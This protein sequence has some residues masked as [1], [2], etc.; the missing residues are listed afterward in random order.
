[1][2]EKQLKKRIY[3]DYAATTPIDR[4][5][6]SAMR[7]YLKERF[8]NAGGLY[9]EGIEAR[10]TLEEARAHIAQG[11]KAK[12]HE[13]IFTSGGTEANNLAIRGVVRALRKSKKKTPHAIVSVIE[14][15]SV[16]E[17]FRE[18]HRE[19]V[20][21]TY[22]PVTSAGIVD[23][24][25]FL[26]AVT[27]ET[28]F[29]SLMYANNEI[30]TL[31]SVRDV[32]K[33]LRSHEEKTGRKIF[34][35]TDASQAALWCPLDVHALCVD[36]LTLDAQKMY[37]PKGVGA[38]YIKQGVPITPVLFGGSQESELR[39]GTENV[40][41]AV[42]LAKAFSLARER[43]KKDAPRVQAL[44]EHLFARLQEDIPQ[45]VINGDRER[46]L[47]NNI[48]ISLPSFEGEFLVIALDEMG[49]AVSTK[50]ACLGDESGGSYV[51]KALG[52]KKKE[53][54]GT[55]RVTLGRE[56]KKN[57]I[58]A[59]MRALKSIIAKFADLV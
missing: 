29:A 20:S 30:G 9:K 16:L 39:P 59:F 11:L 6:L 51:V 2:K 53:Y 27:A 14:H 15:P 28:V 43:Q 41:L 13:V 52:R 19:G 21:V 1:M 34:F 23:P 31:Q 24:D 35:H 45:A 42:G 25:V 36:L 40:A 46:R 4:E 17:C 37:G 10:K 48:N 12:S 56:T 22:L 26:R 38:L 50:S 33:R 7:P 8:G 55:L 44:R 47:P 32:G 18:L 5:V 49:F 58:E 3:L 57:D 54:E